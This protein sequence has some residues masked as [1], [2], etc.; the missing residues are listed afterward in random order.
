MTYVFFVKRYI[1]V[2][3]IPGLRT[4]YDPSRGD[5]IKK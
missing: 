5:R 4:Y 1:T 2:V 3:V